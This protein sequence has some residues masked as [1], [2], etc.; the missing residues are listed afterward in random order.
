MCRITQQGLRCGF[1]NTSDEGQF[2]FKHIRIKQDP[3]FQNCELS[4]FPLKTK[5]NRKFEGSKQ[6]IYFCCRAEEHLAVKRMRSAVA[7]WQSVKKPHLS[8][9]SDISLWSENRGMHVVATEDENYLAIMEMH[10]LAAF[11]V[12]WQSVAAFLCRMHGNWSFFWFTQKCLPAFFHVAPPHRCRRKWTGEQ[13]TSESRLIQIWMIRIPRKFKAQKKLH[14]NLCNANLLTQFKFGWF[15]RIFLG[16]LFQINLHLIEPACSSSSLGFPW[17]LLGLRDVIPS[18]WMIKRRGF[19][20]LK[21]GVQFCRALISNENHFS[22]LKPVTWQNNL[23]CIYKVCSFQQWSLVFWN[24][25]SEHCI[26]C[27][28][29]FSLLSSSERKQKTES[30]FSVQDSLNL[31]SYTLCLFMIACCPPH[32]CTVY[33]SV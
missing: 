20:G 25:D 10:H 2:R 7:A 33:M 9:V 28:R 22:F 23:R 32:K 26:F 19:P 16:F 8:D 13:N 15:E 14:S 21:Y 29:L 30:A 4:T 27:T 17:R 18:K 11:G 24:W 3:L 5:N 31:L 1:E 12:A 6:P